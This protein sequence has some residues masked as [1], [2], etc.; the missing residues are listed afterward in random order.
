M[1]NIPAFFGYQPIPVQIPGQPVP[2]GNAIHPNLL[3]HPA[4]ALH[5]AI[6]AQPVQP[7]GEQ[8]NPAP[9]AVPAPAPEDAAEE[10]TINQQIQ[11]IADRRRLEEVLDQNRQKCLDFL[12][13]KTQGKY[14]DENYE[15]Y[16]NAILNDYLETNQ[17]ISYTERRRILD[18]VYEQHL[19]ERANRRI[20]Y[21]PNVVEAINYIN[22]DT[23]GIGYYR[24]WWGLG[25]I[26]KENRLLPRASYTA[27]HLNSVA[28]QCPP[29]YISIS[30]LILTASSIVASVLIAKWFISHLSP[31]PI[32]TFTTHSACN[33]L[34]PLTTTA[35]I[36]KYLIHMSRVI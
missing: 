33:Q 29:M 6:P 2:P 12:W 27:N 11:Y 10:P 9:A 15:T 30:P 16:C 23:I 1:G 17:I 5:H 22:A 34:L 35:I 36:P 20:R 28:P 25:L 24:P 31:S 8:P 19:A 32:S 14:I 13:V 18:G 26:V 4:N 21:L 3:A 7:A